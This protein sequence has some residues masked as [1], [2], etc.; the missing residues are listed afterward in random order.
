MSKL[1]L[2]LGKGQ[3]FDLEPTIQA[4]L[5]IPGVAKARRGSFIGSVFE[6]EYAFDD[7]S[8]IVRIANDLETIIVEGLG[9]E[10]A[11]FAMELQQRT[12]LPLKAVDMEYSFELRL[13]DYSSRTALVQAMSGV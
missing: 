8:T 6:C 9:S 1:L 10:A 5:S 3:A 7:A 2:Y 11:N 4:I 13:S 12:V